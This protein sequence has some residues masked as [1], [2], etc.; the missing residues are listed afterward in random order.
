MNTNSLAAIP[1]PF[2]SAIVSD[3]WQPGVVDVPEI[4]AEAFAACCEALEVVRSQQRSASVLLH[5]EAGSGKTHLLSRL[6]AYVTGGPSASTQSTLVSAPRAV[7]VAVRMQTSPRLLWRHL[8]E[9]FGEDLLRVA[10]D[11]RSQLDRILLDRLRELRPDIGDAADWLDKVRRDVGR[12][13]SSGRAAAE[14]DEFI[15]RL[16]E[17]AELKP[18]DLSTV[19]GHLLCGRF[20]REA[21]AWLRGESLP[22]AALARLGVSQEEDEDAERGARSVVLSLCRLAGPQIPVVFCFDQLEALQ[23]QT[24]EKMSLAPFGQMVT[25]LHDEAHNTLLISCVLSSFL[26]ALNDGVIEPDRRR[27]ASFGRKTLQALTLEQAAQLIIA[28][29]DSVAELRQLRAGRANNLWPLSITHVQ[30]ALTRAYNTPR[31]LLSFCAEKYDE[32]SNRPLP[33]PKDLSEMWRERAEAALA[34]SSPARTDQVV[35]HGMPL[36][37]AL[38]GGHLKLGESRERDIDLLFEGPRGRTGISLCNHQSVQA[39][40]GL[41]SKLE[42]LAQLPPASRPERLVVLRDARLP[43]GAHAVKT[44][45]HRDT[46]LAQGVKW[47]EPSAEALAA[48]DALRALISDARSGDLSRGGETVA[49]E[50]VEGWLAASLAPAL[51]DLLDDLFAAGGEA[52]AARLDLRD[53]LGELLQ[54]RHVV[55]LA[56]A[57]GALNQPEAAVEECARRHADQFGW[58]GGPPAVLFELTAETFTSAAD[59][60]GE[61]S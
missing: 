11:G 36:L 39:R 5:G 23:V 56:A 51:R 10:A 21:G 49:P 9:K 52:D 19:L 53:A 30:D 18:F 60:L 3:P 32:V 35:S 22:E 14:V 61:R 34:D 15:G 45:Q 1:N 47:V 29:L 31:R 24:Q 48:L 46:L 43:I 25:A 41:P 42:R 17:R 37:V 58:L 26:D 8:R 6:Q 50:T 13:E 40:K 38:G 33:A 20:R 4:H 54:A 55:A 16:S 12:V 28:R 7:I 59:T 44:K 57:A 27:L 2:R